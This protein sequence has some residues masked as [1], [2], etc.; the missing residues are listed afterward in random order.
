MHRESPRYFRLTVTAGCLVAALSVGGNVAAQSLFD[1]AKNALG[2]AL[3]GNSSGNA[4]SSSSSLSQDTVADGLRQAL[5]AGIDLVTAQLGKTDG[6]NTDPVA[7][8]PL[9]ASV[10]RVQALLTTAGLGSYSDEIE[11]RM[12]RAA[13]SAMSDAGDILL[14]AVRQMTMAD[15]RSILDGPQDAATQY[16]RRV[17]GGEIEGKLRPVMNDALAETGAI[18]MYD[19]MMGQYQ[20]LPLVP[21]VKASLGD[22]ATGAAMDGIFHYLAVQEADIRQNPGRWTTDILK[23]VFSAAQ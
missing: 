11:L 10:Q 7:H 14:N 15:A 23:K 4:S 12:N 8:I 3:S 19:Q 22:H 2:G 6:F 17:S 9:P 18:G 13:E 21:D 20:S 16:L 1:A 5:D